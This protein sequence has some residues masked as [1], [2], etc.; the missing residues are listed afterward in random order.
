MRTI[1]EELFAKK[2]GTKTDHTGKLRCFYGRCGF[3]CGWLFMRV[4]YQ[5]RKTPSAKKKKYSN[6]DLAQ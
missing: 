2:R 4:G 3:L 5:G 1:S 6:V